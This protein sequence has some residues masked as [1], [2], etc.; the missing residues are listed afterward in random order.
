MICKK[1]GENNKKGFIFC[2][3]CG[4]PLEEKAS[5]SDGDNNA[6]AGVRR[7]KSY[8]GIIAAV[9]VVVLLGTF[10]AYTKLTGKSGGNNLYPIKIEKSFS[11]WMGAY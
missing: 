3:T 9:V 2:Q 1:C 6:G 11:K 5:A 8:V 4:I 10:F 7:K